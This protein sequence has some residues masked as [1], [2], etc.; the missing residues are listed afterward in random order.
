MEHRRKRLRN[1]ILLIYRTHITII[2]INDFR[3][4]DRPRAHN[5]GTPMY[6][7]ARDSR[8][9]FATVSTTMIKTL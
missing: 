8:G 9:P 1:R 7:N 6:D 3:F 2:I 5:M 4:N